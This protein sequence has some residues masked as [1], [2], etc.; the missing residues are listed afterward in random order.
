MTLGSVP[1]T[2]TTLLAA[3]AAVLAFAAASARASVGPVRATTSCDIRKDGRKLG[4]TYV[5]SISATGVTCPKAKT[6]IKAFNVCR[7][8]NGGAVGTCA[9]TVRTFRC[10]E[11]RNGIPTQFVSRATCR[12]GPRAVKFTYTQFT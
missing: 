12:S 5:T 11:K 3:L 7:K 10:T 8:A 4:T 6:L 2:A 1:R 9:A